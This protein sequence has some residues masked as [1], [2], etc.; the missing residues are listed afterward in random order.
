[1]TFHHSRLQEHCDLCGR[2][3]AS[4]AP[5]VS[6]KIPVPQDYWNGPGD[7]RYRC[8]PCTTAHGPIPGDPKGSDATAGVNAPGPGSAAA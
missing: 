1:M 4:L 7:T 6:W 5:G 8:A 2:F 3:V